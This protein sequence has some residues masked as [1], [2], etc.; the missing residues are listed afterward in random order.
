LVS[1]ARRTSDLLWRTSP[2]LVALVALIPILSATLGGLWLS[3]D[4]TQY[5]SATQNLLAGRG[6]SV[7]VAPDSLRPLTHFPPL[8]PATIAVFGAIFGNARRGAWLLNLVATSV[9][10][11]LAARL[12]ARVAGEKTKAG[13]H[14]AFVA[15]IAMAVANDL[16]LDGSM[17]WSEPMFI[18]LL[19]TSLVLLVG[20]LE[21]ESL[22]DSRSRRLLA[23]AALTAAAS[24]LTRYAG[25]ALVGSCV[26][27]V[28]L[29]SRLS[30]QARLHR[31]LAFGVISSAPLVAWFV[32]NRMQAGSA[33]GRQLA[34]HV[35][36]GS[37]LL[38]G[39]HTLTRWFIPYAPS[40]FSRAIPVAL[41]LGM[42]VYMIRRNGLPTATAVLATFVVTYGA[43]LLVS[44]SVADRA[45][46]LDARILSP[47]LPVVIAIAS[48]AAF[49]FFHYSSHGE[50]DES[51]GRRSRTFRVASGAAFLLYCCSHL[52]GLVAWTRT[53]R[54]Q[55][56]GL[57]P[58][59]HAADELVAAASQIP[60]GARVYSNVPGAL[61]ALTNRVVND[62]PWRV[63]PT[64]LT[65]NPRFDL[66]LRQIAAIARDTPT[67]VVLFDAGS[68]FQATAK[69]VVSSLHIA[70]EKVLRGGEIAL[71]S[72]R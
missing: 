10:I 33:S 1:P 70:S 31:A 62:L 17:L 11:V 71:V 21:A 14:A 37:D 69:D 2:V 35:I 56:L 45:T 58:L 72:G 48:G 24:T 7:F 23:L 42:I 22:G 15:A 30:L 13:A 54:A 28:L 64:S 26:I 38:E 4:S 49:S 47:A 46:P 63:S 68:S 50:R 8:Y 32:R 27:S 57:A 36:S 18:T 9:N 44:I 60:P 59:G 16:A 6:L 66:E 52:A 61:Y 51:P 29:I 67:Y 34:I 20:A 3:Y 5:L 65:A 43:F 55:G 40:W 19:L 39:V 25:A 41:I 12:A 53:A